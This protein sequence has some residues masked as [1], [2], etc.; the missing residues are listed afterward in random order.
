M[1]DTFQSRKRAFLTQTKMDKTE[2]TVKGM[3]S[4]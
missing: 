1:K 3:W 4:A 2:W